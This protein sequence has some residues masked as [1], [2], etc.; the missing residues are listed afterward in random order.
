VRIPKEYEHVDHDKYTEHLGGMQVEVR[1]WYY[2]P[3]TSQR[4]ALP[5]TKDCAKKIFELLTNDELRNQMAQDARESVL[6]N[7]RADK[8]VGL[9][10]YIIDNI[11][12]KDLD[13]TW[14]SKII[15]KIPVQ[16][17]PQNGL[18]TE[19]FVVWCYTTI[20]GN[21]I[22]PKGVQDWTSSIDKGANTRE[23]VYKFF[24]EEAARQYT[25]AK[26]LKESQDKFH[27]RKEEKVDSAISAI[28][29]E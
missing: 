21:P 23:Q 20:L 3:E 25:V 1:D 2:E 6:E 22:D 7:H 13:E 16:D 24:F 29:V 11:N 5:D 15:P 28:V 4:R 9:W 27:N 14:D 26:R 8:V 12:P 10:K 19:Q 18:S 17:T